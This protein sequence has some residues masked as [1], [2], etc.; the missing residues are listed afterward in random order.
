MSTADDPL[1]STPDPL[2]AILADYLQQVD[3][4]LGAHFPR[5]PAARNPR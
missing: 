2:D 1:R 3:A 4:G 5:S